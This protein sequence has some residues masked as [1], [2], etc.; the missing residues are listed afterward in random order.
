M[1][2]ANLGKAKAGGEGKTRQGASNAG[3]TVKN[4]TAFR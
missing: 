4:Q 2:N 1:A 3:S